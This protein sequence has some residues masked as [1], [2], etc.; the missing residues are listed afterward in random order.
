MLE[1][2]DAPIKHVVQAVGSSSKEKAA[3]FVQKHAPSAS[4]TLYSSYEEVYNDPEVD[5]IYIGTPHALHLKNTLDAIAAGKNVLCEKPLT[6]N[7]KE[8]EQIIAAAAAKNVFVMEAVWTRFFPIM[9][10][11]QKLLHKDKIIGDISRVFVDFGLNMPIAAMDKNARTA[12]LSLGAGSLLDTGIYCLTFASVVLDQHPGNAGAP[13]PKIA[14]SMTF[15]NGADE[16]TSVIINYEQ[17]KAQAILTTS[18]LSKSD[19][20]FGRIEGSKGEI[21]VGGVAASRPTYILIREAGKEERKLDFP[22]SGWGFHYEADSVALDVLAG[23]KESKLMPLAESLRMMKTMDS[24]R[25][26]NGLVY[27][28]DG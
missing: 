1:R 25:A 22:I 23:N 17:L 27:P 18:L 7:A 3:A 2:P 15:T 28:Q 12:D 5:V 10:E 21:L 19:K 20:T 4:P 24:I 13:L 9:Q 16:M 26:S 6:I 8:T 14:S 11:L